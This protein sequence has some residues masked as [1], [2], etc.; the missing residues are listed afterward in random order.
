[1]EKIREGEDKKA[2]NTGESFKEEGDVHS[3]SL[4]FKKA[5]GWSVL[6]TEHWMKQLRV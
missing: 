6:R 2:G 5:T 1:M 4:R 3:G